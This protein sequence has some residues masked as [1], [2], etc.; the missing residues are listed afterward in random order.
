M[1]RIQEA[2]AGWVLAAFGLPE[3]RPAVVLIDALAPQGAY[4]MHGKR[5][6]VCT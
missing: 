5:K 2:S 1:L 3:W 4:G 6:E